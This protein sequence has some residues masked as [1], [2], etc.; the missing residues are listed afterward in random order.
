[1]DLFG[2]DGPAALPPARRGA[3]ADAAHIG[4]VLARAFG[5]DPVAAYLF[6]D[7]ARRASGLRRFF[8]LQLRHSYLPRGEVWVAGAPA[9]AGRAPADGG[10]GAESAVVRG[11]ALWTRPDLAPLRPGDV[12]F[13]FRL[14]T[15]FGA[16]LPA[17]RRLG[18]LLGAHHPGAPHWYLG[19]IGVEPHAQRRGL[20]GAL[21]APVLARCDAERRPAYL[22]CSLES[23]LAFYERHGFSCTAEV[24]LAAGPRLWL[25]WREPRPPP[26]G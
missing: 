2:A 22:E 17:A 1:M 20:G 14:A 7:P 21:L 25:M 4:A 10:R 13:P 26:P 3:P 16:H 18:R 6:P 11:A 9:G 24:G 5:T 15:L 19:T 12:V 23:N 8:A